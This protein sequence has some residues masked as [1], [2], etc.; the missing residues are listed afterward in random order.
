MVPAG[1]EKDFPNIVFNEQFTGA[2]AKQLG[3]DLGA[4]RAFELEHDDESSYK[5]FGN[6]ING[7]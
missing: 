2:L 4:K 1:R 3:I 6:T 5:G 7:L